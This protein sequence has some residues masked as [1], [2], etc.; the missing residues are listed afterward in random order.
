MIFPFSLFS[1]RG[2]SVKNCFPFVYA[3][4]FE[5]MFLQMFKH[6]IIK[7]SANYLLFC[8]NYAD[9]NGKILTANQQL[10]MFGPWAAI[11]YAPTKK[12]LV[13]LCKENGLELI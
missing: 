3:P 13:A 1:K 12:A 10:E 11:A 5:R 6:E 7:G 2:N 8:L 9:E 4:M